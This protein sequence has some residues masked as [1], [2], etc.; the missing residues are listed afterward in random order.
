MLALEAMQG[1]APARLPALLNAA[2]VRAA[3]ASETDGGISTAVLALAEGDAGCMASIKLKIVSVVVL[4]AGVLAGGFGAFAYPHLAARQETEKSTAEFQPPAKKS[5]TPQEKPSARRDRYGDPLPPGVLARMGTIRLRRGYDLF[6]LPQRD[7]FL[8]VSYEGEN[9]NVFVWRMSTGELQRRFVVPAGRTGVALSPDGTTLGISG[10]DQR[11]GKMRV[12]FWDVAT[13][14]MTGE[15][16]GAGNVVA[17]AFTADGKILATSE[18]GQT[19]RLWAWRRGTELRRIKGPKTNCYQVEFSP[20]GKV[21]A[22]ACVQ[23]R[24]VHLWD[25]ATGRE[26]HAF[27]GGP[28]L[29]SKIAFRPDGKALATAD[30]DD[31]TVYLWDVA[32]GKEVRRFTSEHRIFSLAFSPDGK[33]L[34]AGGGPENKRFQ[35]P[36]PIHL[37]D[38]EDGK[39]V[40]CLSGH[41]YTAS[42]LIF[43]T[44]GKKLV[45]SGS[46][47]TM[48][49][50][51]V[52]TGK[53][54]LPFA[55]HESYVTSVAFSPDGRTLA[56]GSLDGT[57]RLWQSMTGKLIR[58]FE[59]GVSPQVLHVAFSPDGRT[60]IS[61][62][63]DGSLRVWDVATGRQIKRFPISE[64]VY[65]HRFAY[66]PDGRTL[67]VWHSDATI[68]LLDAATGKEKQR[69]SGNANDDVWLNFAPD[70]RKLAA[71]SITFRG[72]NGVLQIWDVTTGTRLHKRQV[73]LSGP[74]VFSPD[75]RTVIGGTG[76]SY[77]SPG[78]T[79]RTFHRWDIITG[80]DRPFTTVQP[81]RIRGLAIS[82]DGRTLAWG[83]AEGTITLWELTAGQVRRRLKGHHSYVQ[84][85]AFSPDGKTLASGSADTTALLWDITGVPFDHPPLPLSGDKVQSLWTDLA[86]K[87]AGKA[88]DAVGLLTASPEQATAMLKSKL[89]PA[90]EPADRRLV[91]RLVTDLDSE[92][93]AVREMAMEQLR[94]LG[95]RAEPG[96][97]EALLGKPALEV[98]KR[99]EELLE[100]VRAAAAKPE[101]LRS[102]RAVEVLEHIGNAEARN[103]LQTLAAGPVATRLTLAAKASLERL[104]RRHD[105]KP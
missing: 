85:L 8:S 55:E 40:R 24:K 15:L 98:R 47:G 76:D 81:A 75:G 42:S 32:T 97:R 37:W 41:I 68:R 39:E 1:T 70:S 45:S 21:L 14:K 19:L 31:K 58:V 80:E 86:S 95:E 53:D 22:A 82:P 13:E 72:R 67:A 49:V 71:L 73:A 69:L 92:D 83:D 38:V 89:R 29:R 28:G 34:A 20:D 78:I 99:I 46:G 16:M 64:G 93:F 101:K 11:R 52:A 35:E 36:S 74:I 23:E 77:S 96:L 7:S 103:V 43:S 17:L 25:T 6:R 56:T 61:D 90:P 65:S 100:G 60:L 30:W 102:L 4:M 94:Q 48:S 84:S 12:L 62:R 79:E 66:S 26:L 54:L 2:I 27:G 104:A 91:A 57:I 44:D 3:S 87:D 10:Y 88:F 51:D 5:A 18:E 59:G 63:P 9:T 50:W 105:P 33:I